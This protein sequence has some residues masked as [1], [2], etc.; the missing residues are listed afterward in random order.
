[1]KKSWSTWSKATTTNLPTQHIH[2][3]YTG[4]ELNPAILVGGEH[5]HIYLDHPCTPTTTNLV[6]GLN[7]GVL[8]VCIVW[9]SG[10]GYAALKRTVVGEWC[11]DNLCGCHLQSQGDSERQSVT[12]QVWSDESERP[13]SLP[14]SLPV[15]NCSSRWE[16]IF[17]GPFRASILRWQWFDRFLFSTSDSSLSTY[18]VAFQQL[19]Y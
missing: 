12:L 3:Y 11:F 10:W 6:N 2:V 7:P 4:L 18:E 16:S 19:P 17:E 15:V 8:V 5:S 1:M 13:T 9:S 14:Y